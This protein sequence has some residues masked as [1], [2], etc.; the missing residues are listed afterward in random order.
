M[1]SLAAATVKPATRAVGRVRLG[2]DKS[3]SHRYA[4]LAALADGRTTITK[5]S[6]GADCATTLQC[7]RN[8]GVA[9]RSERGDDGL[10]NLHKEGRRPRGPAAAPVPPHAAT[11]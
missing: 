5:Y 7:L 11:Y 6:S 8:L 4:M 10:W 3:I 2:G 9:I 1:P